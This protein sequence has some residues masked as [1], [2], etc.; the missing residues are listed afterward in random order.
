MILSM[1][2]VLGTSATDNSV[3]QNAPLPVGA[4]TLDRKSAT[5]MTL[6]TSLPGSM[7]ALCVAVTVF[8]HKQLV[9]WLRWTDLHVLKKML[10]WNNCL[11]FFYDGVDP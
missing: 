4:E 1:K 7:R 9:I 8:Y 6:I 3:S 2:P 10:K 5:D 11:T